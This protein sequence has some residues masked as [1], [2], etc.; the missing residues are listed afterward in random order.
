VL[1]LD[2]LGHAHRPP[3]AR[4][5]EAEVRQGAGAA[6]AGFCGRIAATRSAS[7]STGRRHHGG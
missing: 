2:E 7:G 5:R 6:G 4:H 1:L 3:P